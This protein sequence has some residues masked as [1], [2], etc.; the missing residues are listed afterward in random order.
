MEKKLQFYLRN[1]IHNGGS[2]LHLKSGAII[3]LRVN[4]ELLKLGD[5]VLTHEE[6]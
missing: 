3:R 1:L 5:R 6:L 2:D 4:G